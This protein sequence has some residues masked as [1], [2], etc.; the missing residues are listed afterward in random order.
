MLGSSVS[1]CAH[2]PA[3]LSSSATD[4]EVEMRG[5]RG[6]RGGESAW[7]EPMSGPGLVRADA[8]RLLVPVPV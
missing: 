2:G 1:A 3:S 8:K 6:W 5:A 7:S 4:T